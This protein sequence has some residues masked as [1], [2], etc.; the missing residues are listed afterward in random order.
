VV[1]LPIRRGTFEV[2]SRREIYVCTLF[3][4]NIIYTYEFVRTFHV[5]NG[6]RQERVLSLY[7]FAVYLDDLSLELNNIWAGC[8]M[9]EVLFELLDVC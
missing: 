4:S 9:S 1:H 2:S 7:L 3:I 5:T 8:Y 6:V